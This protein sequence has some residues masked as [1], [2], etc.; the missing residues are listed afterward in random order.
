VSSCGHECKPGNA[1][2]TFPRQTSPDG[3]AIVYEGS[4]FSFDEG[5]LIE[6]EYLAH[7]TSSGWR[8]TNLTPARMASKGGGGFMAFK[9]DLGESVIEE[10]EGQRFPLN[11]EAPAGFPNLYTQRSGEPLALTPFLAE[12]P[13]NRT[14]SP[15]NSMEI[16]FAGASADF[17]RFFF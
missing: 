10:Y 14:T 8:S 4:A 1:D 2:G 7:R 11:P 16:S 6:N 9:D 17:S 3:N 5:A 12:A 13:P 15:L